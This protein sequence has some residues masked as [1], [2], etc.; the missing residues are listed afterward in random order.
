MPE[1]FLHVGD[2]HADGQQPGGHGVGSRWGYLRLPIAGVAGDLA[3]HLVDALTGEGRRTPIC[4]LL[5]T[6]KQR[7][8]P[9][10]AD[11]QG[12]KARQFGAH[13]DF[14]A[15]AALAILDDN[16]ALGKAYVFDAQGH[17]FRHVRAGLQQHLHHHPDLAALC[18]GLVDETQFFL[19]RQTCRGAAVFLR[20]TQAGLARDCMGYSQQAGTP[21]VAGAEI[22]QAYE[23]RQLEWR[24]ASGTRHRQIVDI[25]HN[26]RYY[27]VYIVNTKDEGV[28]MD[29]DI[30][31]INEIAALAGVS[32]QAVVNWRSRAADFPRPI[33]ELASGPVFRS[34]QIRA[35]LRR[36]NRKLEDLHNGL[37][38]YV[39]LKSFRNDSD[40]LANCIKRVVDRLEESVTS[41]DRPGMLLGRIQSGKTRAF[42]GVIASV[43][44]RG[45][46]IALVLTK[47]TK[48]LSAQTVSRL[49]ADFAEFIDE[50]E[51]MVMDIMKLPG[52]L[53]RSELRRKI[54][55]VAK[56]QAQ[57]LNRLI[58]FVENQT[59]L[60]KKKV[61]IVDDEADLAS[62]RFVRK[63]GDP[64]PSQGT[65]A[66]QI[67]ELRAL[68]K[69]IA[70]LQ[71]TA[72]PYSLYLQPESYEDT[73]HPKDFVFRP[74]RPA[75]TEVLPI[76]SAYVGGDH[77]FGAFEDDDP[78]SKLIVE[79]SE[80]EQN[81][82][83]RPDQRRINRERVL[84]SPNTAGLRRA[85][86]TFV[87]AAGVRQWQQRELGEKEKKYSMV[88]HND[89][90][91]ASHAWQSQLIDWICEAIID[92]AES[93][94]NGL[95]PM[96]DEAYED[97]NSS[98][99][100][101]GRQMPPKDDAFDIFVDALQ[102]DDVVV[103]KV[104]SDNDVMALLDEKAELKL[105]TA[106][107][108]FVGGNILDR[109]ITIPNLIS[110][111]YGRNPRVM[112][113]DTVLQHSR[114]YGNRRPDDLAVTRFYTSRAVFDRLYAINDFEKTLRNAFETGAHDQGVVFI[115]SDEN[116]GIRPCAPNK[117]LLS[118]VVAVSR[119]HN[120][121][122][123]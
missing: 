13:R 69:E 117:V 54:V 18:I 21:R 50:D 70:F 24:A 47:G 100:A 114:M 73:S 102:S 59:G 17:E 25:V 38:F 97:L 80:Q 14:A 81:A 11:V 105:R 34:A 103:E 45:F 32:S 64:T 51:L 108:V 122:A 39:R 19:K 28:S 89:T 67:D 104:N 9:A 92:A 16:D 29:Q 46:D 12:Q 44:D 84:Q 79:V 74:K 1:E 68:S 20:G 7:P 55:I 82:L 4:A 86:T 76:H 33:K 60:Q 42:V 53:T 35:W 3:D 49:N 96:F 95:R 71:V 101:H 56:K 41:N 48:T 90:Q 31:G 27:S 78:R 36:N 43:F 77:Y 87:V 57:N 115:R 62:V 85:I 118:D 65:I 119:R 66:D 113:S 99:I 88:I 116:G 75:F 98:V 109:G 30:V 2:V 58:H 61:L 111:Y 94:P 10:A 6:D 112:Q 8:G 110:F 93:N 37:A 83:R 106:Y 121:L 91:R 107:N 123:D 72:T 15:L 22:N 63:K 5:P 23:R 52:K 120:A 40:E 26:S